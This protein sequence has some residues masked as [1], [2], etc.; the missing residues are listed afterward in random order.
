MREINFALQ[1]GL[2]ALAYV[3]QHLLYKADVKWC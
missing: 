2:E 3:P 1:T